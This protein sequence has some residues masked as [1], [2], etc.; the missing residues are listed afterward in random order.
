M[1]RDKKGQNSRRSP[2][3]WTSSMALALLL[4]ACGD[5]SP[6][7][8]G[9]VGEGGVVEGNAATGG[10]DA[11]GADAGG[12]DAG[13][14]DSGG[15]DAAGAD[16]GG[17]GAGD[18]ATGGVGQGSKSGM[19]VSG[20]STGELDASTGAGDAKRQA[21][22]MFAPGISKRS[23]DTKRKGPSTGMGNGKGKGLA[24]ARQQTGH[25]GGA[26]S[27]T[28]HGEKTLQQASNDHVTM[29]SSK[30]E[31]SSSVNVPLLSDDES[32]PVPRNLKIS[33][34]Q[35]SSSS[36]FL[37]EQPREN[38]AAVSKEQRMVQ[39]PSQ[40]QSQQPQAFEL[41]FGGNP[42]LLEAKS[43]GEPQAAV[44]NVHQDMVDDAAG[45]QQQ[46]PVSVPVQF[47]GPAMPTVEL[48]ISDVAADGKPG[49]T[50]RPLKLLVDPSSTGVHVFHDAVKMLNLAPL[51]TT[52]D[53]VR[54]PLGLTSLVRDVYLPG[55]VARAYVN[56]GKGRTTEAIPLQVIDSPHAPGVGVTKDMQRRMKQFFLD[57]RIDG[58]LGIGAKTHLVNDAP[59]SAYWYYEE[60]HTTPLGEGKFGADQRL[61]GLHAA[62]PL[63]VGMTRASILSLPPRGIPNASG[64]AGSGLLTFGIEASK[65]AGDDKLG[66][67]NPFP[68]FNP[69]SALLPEELQVHEPETQAAWTGDKGI[70]WERLVDHTLV[71]V[72]PDE[73][74]QYGSFLVYKNRK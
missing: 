34:E 8:G 25:S 36:Q 67:L 50:S 38:S 26:N 28:P 73:S 58:I 47:V 22:D 43:Q 45:P 48:T 14:A 3:M 27:A 2:T 10:A 6:P 29:K 42:K 70:A 55:V 68:G 44:Q 21:G 64:D 66:K 51:T 1:A 19:G 5:G 54:F 56:V 37:A 52:Q 57:H 15:A 53:G 72:A 65:L 13:G 59:Y 40:L 7:N 9:R 61:I 60:G 74:A 71:I 31:Q 39:K 24:Q 41:T 49:K 17:A 30:L 46:G 12:A 35:Q 16:A 33:A 18:A 23:A 32:A 11:G 69:V 63:P 62:L 20:K 4:G